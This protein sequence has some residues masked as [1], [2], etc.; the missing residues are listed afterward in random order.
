ML[1]KKCGQIMLFEVPNFYQITAVL[2]K[3][4]EG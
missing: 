3:P 1:E 4:Q 2:R